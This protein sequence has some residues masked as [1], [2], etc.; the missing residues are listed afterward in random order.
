MKAWILS[1]KKPAAAGACLIIVLAV[2]LG[3]LFY[4]KNSAAP[5]SEN[6]ASSAQ[7]NAEIDAWGEVTYSR[8]EDI[9]IDFPSI[10][11]KLEVQEG[12]EPVV[13]FS[14]DT[15]EL[16]KNRAV[17]H[18]AWTNDATKEIILKNIHRSPLYAG[19]IEGV[20]PRYCPSF[21]D[22]IMRFTDKKRHQLFIEPCG[23]DTEELYLQ[24]MSSSLPEEVQLAF[25]RTIAG[26]EHVEIMRCAYAI[27]YDCVDPLQLDPHSNFR[28]YPACMAQASSTAAPAMKRLPHRGFWRESTPR[29]VH[30]K[31]NRSFSTVRARISARW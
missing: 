8:M 5:P 7:Q 25:Y 18:I 13:P 17:C 27:E 19:K 21:E 20:G 14:Y 26:L 9:S 10:V 16:P 31:K 12:D 11:T 3:I 4:Q 22:K 15:A 2:V 29:G 30:R 23:M 1:H 28:I 6:P 24:G